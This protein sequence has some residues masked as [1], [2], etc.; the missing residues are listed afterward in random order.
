M[1]KNRE[2]LAKVF[3]I[4]FVLS[5]IISYSFGMYFSD[6]DCIG[7]NCRICYEINLIKST[8]D[9]LLTL[10]LIYTFIKKFLRCISK[11]K[12][13]FSSEYHLTPIILKVMLLE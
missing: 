1:C 13:V 5:L 9:N 6:H 2:V 4:I 3:F 8:F 7:S 10:L 12:Y 11:L